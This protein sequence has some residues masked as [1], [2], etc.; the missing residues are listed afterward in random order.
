MEPGEIG[1]FQDV[2][3]KYDIQDNEILGIFYSKRHPL[4]VQAVKKK[5][6]GKKL[7]EEEITALVHDMTDNK[8]SDTLV[9]YYFNYSMGGEL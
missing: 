2:Y 6:F 3:E 4:S 7:T 1:V 5:L 9:T 8:I